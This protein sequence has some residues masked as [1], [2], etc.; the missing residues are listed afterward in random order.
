MKTR[1]WPVNDGLRRASG[2]HTSGF[3]CVSI[4]VVVL[5][6]SCPSRASADI[7]NAFV[8]SPGASTLLGADFEAISGSFTFNSTTDT[9]SGVSITLTGTGPSAGVYTEPLAKQII[10]AMIITAFAPMAELEIDF[11]LPLATSPDPLTEVEWTLVPGEGLPNGTPVTDLAPVGFALFPVPEP[12]SAVLLSTV[13][14]I[15]GPVAR[16]KLGR[17]RDPREPRARTA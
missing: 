3:F 2:V 13:V 9:E 7:I 12:T 15:V 1:T 5:L 11:S 14:A 8:F 6:F 16:R 10:G 17:T 4:L